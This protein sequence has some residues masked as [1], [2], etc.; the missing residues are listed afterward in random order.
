MTFLARIG[1]AGD[2]MKRIHSSGISTL[3][4]LALLAGATSAQTTPADI[5]DLSLDQLSNIKVTSVAKKEQKLSQVAAAVYVITQE[6]I[7]R[8]GL[9]SVPELLRLAP[10]LDV[11]RV[12]GNQWSISARG[13]D[14]VYANKLLVLID[15]R[16]V[17][18]PIFSGVYWDLGMPMLEDIDRIEVIRGPGATIWGANAVLGVINIITKKT[19]DTLGTM[20]TGAAGNSERVQG[21]ARFG[22]SFGATTYRASV[23]GADNEELQQANGTGANDG[24]S[25][26]QGAFRIDHAG[27]KDSWTIEANLFRSSTNSTGIQVSLSAQS[28]VL[29]P[30]QIDSLAGDITS[31]WRRRVS[32]TAELRIRSYYEYADRPVSVASTVASQT[33]DNE[34]QFDFLAAKRH[35]LSV[36]AGE[37]LIGTLVS[38][39]SPYSFNPSSTTYT[40]VNGYAQ[41]EIHFFD[42]QLLFTAGAKLEHNGLSGWAIEPSA[43]LV[44]L[45]TKRQSVWTSVARAVRTPTVYERSVTLPFSIIPASPLSGG[46][47]VVPEVV[48]TSAFGNELVDDYEA[49]YRAELTKRLS[50][51]IDLYYDRASKIRAF[52]PGAPS[53]VFGSSPYLAIPA[54]IANGFDGVG[55]GA[56]SAL[57]WEVFRAWKLAGSYSYNA[58]R[59]AELA[60]LPAGT[61]DGSGAKPTHT[62]LKL[63]SYWNLAKSLQLDTFAYWTNQADVY[64]STPFNVSV[65]PY[66]RLDVR[67]GYRIN[68]H[69]QLSLSGQNLL[70]ARHLEGVPELLTEYSY[71]NRSAYLKSTWRF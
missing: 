7:A 22:G 58:M 26:E 51:D 27:K 13:F 15:G 70:Q 23:F 49:G 20:V 63:Q 6:Q 69:W 1:A 35:H 2:Q 18:S 32:D 44:W 4:L 21:G 11:Q 28:L 30:A 48:G 24:S 55:K 29:V 65:P 17:Y 3:S 42:D 64:S 47:P 36:G 54:S 46:L 41:D 5:T 19:T 60:G 9:T 38:T 53:V 56:E 67:L 50:F 62:K 8:S 16:S 68:A 52:V 40:D 66:W 57:S 33:W 14:G 71:V 43:N 45:L 61:I 31:E 12:N 39:R 37:R 25:S 10:G 34:V 59:T